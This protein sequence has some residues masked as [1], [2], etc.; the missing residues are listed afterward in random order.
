MTTTYAVMEVSPGAYGEIRERL[1]SVGYGHAV[2]DAA[3]QVDMHGLALRPRRQRGQADADLGRA[4]VDAGE[5][6]V[7]YGVVRAGVGCSCPA[8]AAP[9]QVTLADGMRHF[10]DH[11]RGR[12]P[13]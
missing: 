3:Q 6:L 10:A 5:H 1:L 7:N 4:G 11:V 13:C 8:Y 2:D 9:D 12:V